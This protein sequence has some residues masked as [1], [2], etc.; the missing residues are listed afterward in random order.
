MNEEMKVMENTGML[1][2]Q[3]IGDLFASFCILMMIYWIVVFMTMILCIPFVW[4]YKCRENNAD[5]IDNKMACSQAYKRKD[6]VTKRKKNKSSA[7]DH[8]SVSKAHT[9]F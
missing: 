7:A 1:L 6:R 9:L 8:K 4:L 2:I 3:N 5:D